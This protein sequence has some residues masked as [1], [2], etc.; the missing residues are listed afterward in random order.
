[1]ATTVINQT[2]SLPSGETFLPA[3]A[4][5]V[6]AVVPAGVVSADL[7]ILAGPMPNLNQSFDGRIHLDRLDGRGF[8]DVGG[9]AGN[10]GSFPPNKN[11]TGTPVAQTLLVHEHFELAPG[12][13]YY[14]DVVVVNGPVNVTI[15]LV[16]N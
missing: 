12:M 8:V 2:K 16:L 10:G 4:P 7:T 3:G 13:R 14:V 11:G 1:M 9:L 5:A 6:P 15:T